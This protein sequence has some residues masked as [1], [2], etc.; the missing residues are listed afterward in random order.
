[1]ERVS[2]RREMVAAMDPVLMPGRF[3][4]CTVEDGAL[5]AEALATFRE[6]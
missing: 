6:E 5:A 2:G 1:M 3:V 4:F